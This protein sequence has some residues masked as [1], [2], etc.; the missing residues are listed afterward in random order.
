MFYDEDEETLLS[1][2][3]ERGC[4]A[5]SLEIGRTWRRHRVHH[6]VS[7]RRSALLAQ[8]LC[9]CLAGEAWVDFHTHPQATTLG[10]FERTRPLFALEYCLCREKVEEMYSDCNR[11]RRE[12]GR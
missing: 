8:Y 7:P 10:R 11:P 4:P 9:L 1:R 12:R 6:H 3:I 5:V 2:A